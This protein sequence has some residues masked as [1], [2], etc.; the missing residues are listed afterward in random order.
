MTRRRVAAALV[1]VAVAVGACSSGD[2]GNG[3]P[4]A[5]DGSR[6]DPDTAGVIESATRDA[7]VVDGKR[8]RLARAVQV[9]STI[10]LEPVPLVGRVG[11][12]AQLGTSGNTADWIAVFG[13]AAMVP[14]RGR[15]TFYTGELRD[16]DGDDLVFKDGTVVRSGRNVDVP[17]SVVGKQVNVEI[18]V[19]TDRAQS[20]VVAAI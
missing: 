9:F 17:R 3:G 13:A 15:V 14:G 16:V 1:A 2:D 5:L 19:K 8:Y 6:R 7:V 4:V 10:T 11:Q 18:D 20:V 12:Y